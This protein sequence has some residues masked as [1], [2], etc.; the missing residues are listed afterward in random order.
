[1]KQK[2]VLTFGWEFPPHNLGGLGVACQGIVDGLL[3]HGYKVLMVLPTSVESTQKD[4]E[5]ISLNPELMMVKRIHS[6]LQPYQTSDTYPD[7]E[8]KLYGETLFDEVQR[9]ALASK[10]L[11][12]NKTFNVIHAHDWMTFKAA[13]EL[14]KSSKKPLVV[15]VH[16]TELDRA[17]E[18]HI[19]RK[20]F[21]LEKFGM[22]A[23]DKVVAVSQYTKNKIVDFYDIPSK[24]IEVVY[25]AA[26]N[27]TAATGDNCKLL[28]K[29]KLVLFVGR[30]TFQKGPEYFL[31]AAKKVLEF[32]KDVTF[33]VVG[34]GDLQGKLVDIV[35][36][37]GLIDK[38]LF[39][40]VQRGQ[41]L[42]QL[43]DRADLFIMP[44]VSEPFGLTA[45]EAVQHNTPVIISKQSGAREVLKQALKVD[46]WD[47][48][49]MA[50]HIQAVLDSPD[51]SLE[52]V[53]K[54]AEE[55]N[56]LSWKESSASCIKLYESLFI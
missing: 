32:R 22:K 27:W 44:S 15:H 48:E 9:Y 4:L 10:K 40:G 39:A 25:N 36:K 26:P 1:M 51:A 6:L 42:R 5:I 43:Y 49:N 54:M 11:L 20:I 56:L 12:K 13:S 7:G 31:E 33:V 21:E 30:L 16:S 47:V 45:L 24:K 3:G 35:S 46:Y 34:N 50:A 55:I 17:S 23:A 53:K 18:K 41:K 38:I 52:Q 19:D 2:T 14:K 8:H 37:C 29:D 28:G